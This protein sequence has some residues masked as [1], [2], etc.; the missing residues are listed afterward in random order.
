MHLPDPRVGELE[1]DG[2]R[3]A[4]VRATDEDPDPWPTGSDDAD[5]GGWSDADTVAMI[6]EE[7][8]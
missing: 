6:H 8:W 7:P 3:P 1:P 4:S 2:E 5:D